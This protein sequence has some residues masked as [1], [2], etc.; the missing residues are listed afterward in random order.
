MSFISPRH[1]LLMN[2]IQLTMV[3]HTWMVV[4]GKDSL[5]WRQIIQPTSHGLPSHRK[6]EVVKKNGYNLSTSYKVT[7]KMCVCVYLYYIYNIYIRV[8]IYTYKLH[9]QKKLLY[10]IFVCP[11]IEKPPSC[12]MGG[13]HLSDPQ[14]RHIGQHRLYLECCLMDPLSLSLSLRF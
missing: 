2:K 5:Y 1:T 11:W 13:G 10:C 8:Y 12:S 4:S 6:S 3:L 14:H 7:C 9:R